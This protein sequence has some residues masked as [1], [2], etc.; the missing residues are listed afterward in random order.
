M[1]SDDVIFYAGLVCGFVAMAAL[2][3][4]LALFTL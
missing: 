2:I 4:Y 1:F 3:G